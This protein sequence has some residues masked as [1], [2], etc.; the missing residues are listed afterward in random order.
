MWTLNTRVLLD[1]TSLCVHLDAV[2]LMVP[3]CRTF[4]S[5]DCLV[6]KHV[7]LPV[8]PSC[9]LALNSLPLPWEEGL[10]GTWFEGVRTE[11]QSNE[12]CV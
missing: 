2:G 4:R 12:R 1:P 9:G 5:S 8:L 7:L 6:C 3:L 10:E 11:A